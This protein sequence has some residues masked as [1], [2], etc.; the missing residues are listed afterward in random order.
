MNLVS[1]RPGRLLQVFCA[2]AALALLVAGCGD[3]GPR[4]SPTVPPASP[5]SSARFEP[6]VVSDDLA[7]GPNRFVA[8][9]L[10][11]GDLV[12]DARLHFRF[13]KVDEATNRA[14]LSSETDARPLTVTKNFTHVDRD[15]KVETHPL[16]TIGVYV[17]Q[18]N[19]DRPGSWG[20]E[21]TGSTRDGQAI[22]VLDPLL[23][24]R[25]RS[26]SIGIGQPAPPSRQPLL[27]DVAGDIGQIDTS[28]PPDPDMHQMT[29]ASAIGSGRPTVIS[30]SSPAFCVS[31]TCGPTKDIVDQLYAQH[32][33][34]ASFIHVEP[35]DVPRARKGE[36][37]S[38]V[39]TMGEWGL[40]TEPWTFMVDKTGR[41]AAKFQG[42]V[43]ID[44]LEAALRP[45]LS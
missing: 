34:Q 33:G 43:D 40:T 16:G 38:P 1:P 7:V 35:Y 9:L 44:E 4:P 30:F 3:G 27:S 32:K 39:P 8:G 10:Q 15:G 28:N 14:T 42:I 36:A 21:I 41:V 12:I 29:I 18:V 11:G 6:V 37:L 31:Q 5:R 45:L 13:F 2:F 20:V 22:P 26:A 24:V 19:F 17:A 23:A 25:E